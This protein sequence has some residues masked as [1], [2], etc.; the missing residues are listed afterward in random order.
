MRNDLTI[1]FCRQ[2]GGLITGNDVKIISV[3]NNSNNGVT[4]TFYVMQ[5]NNVLA[6]DTLENAVKVLYPYFNMMSHITCLI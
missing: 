1:L 3:I 4:V 5:G 2:T 6:V